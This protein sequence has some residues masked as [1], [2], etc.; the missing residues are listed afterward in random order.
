VHSP[1]DNKSLNTRTSGFVSRAK[2]RT[3]RS[4]ET[5]ATDQKRS[6]LSNVEFLRQSEITVEIRYDI[7]NHMDRIID[8]LNRSNQLNFTKVRLVSDE[9]RRRFDHQLT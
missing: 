7:E 2:T 6:S 4:L 9:D 3:A 8:L 5:R 1:S